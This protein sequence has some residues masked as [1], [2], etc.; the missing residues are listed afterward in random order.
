MSQRLQPLQTNKKAYNSNY[1]STK[2]ANL[3][4]NE[5]T[6]TKLAK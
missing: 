6:K 4:R 2:V 1:N 3:A 5:Q